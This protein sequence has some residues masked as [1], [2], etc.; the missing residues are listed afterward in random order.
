MRTVEANDPGSPDNQGFVVSH[1]G[2]NNEEQWEEFRE[3]DDVDQE[4]VRGWV[5]GG[6]GKG[7][8]SPNGEAQPQRFD[9]PVAE[10]EVVSHFYAQSF[11][12]PDDDRVI[13]AMLDE[14]GP[15]GFTYRQLGITAEQLRG[16]HKERRSQDEAPAP[17]T[18][19]QPQRQRQILRERLNSRS[20]TVHHR[21]LSD[22]GL[23]R[24]GYDIARGIKGARGNN[25]D[26]LF[27]L[28]GREIAAFVG[29]D[30]GTRPNWSLPKLQVA[31]DSLDEIGDE[32]VARIRRE[33]EKKDASG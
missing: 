28:L 2:L 17:P 6:A 3:L 27:T 22:L 4:T 10:N 24:A 7:G 9:V 29:E 19:T 31:Y 26:A 33:L 12:D 25:G 5:R 32:L 18:P 8:E 20:K 30:P 1:I 11:L 14:K 13:E 23:Y 16:L 15:G 21:I